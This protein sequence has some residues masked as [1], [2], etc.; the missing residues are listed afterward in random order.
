MLVWQNRSVWQSPWYFLLAPKFKASERISWRFPLDGGRDI[1]S[2]K[3]A[4]PVRCCY[5][6]DILGYRYSFSLRAS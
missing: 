2:P 5:P 6:W 3:I 4:K 1:V